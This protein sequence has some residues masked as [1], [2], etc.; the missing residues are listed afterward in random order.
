MLTN[1]VVRAH[2]RFAHVLRFLADN[3]HG[4]IQTENAR[5][6]RCVLPGQGSVDLPRHVPGAKLARIP[7][8]ENDYTFLLQPKDIIG[9]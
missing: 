2:S 9:G 1:H 6:P 4:R 5:S 3:D 8:I 7:R